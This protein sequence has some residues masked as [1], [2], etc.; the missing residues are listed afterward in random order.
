MELRHLRYFT[1]VAGELHFGRAAKL[2]RM[3]QPPLSQQIRSLEKELGVEL[4][5]R[6]KRE[7]RLTPAGKAILERA[8]KVLE[9]V[10]LSTEV[11]RRAAR[12]ETGTLEIGYVP[13]TDLA[14]LPPVIRRFRSQSP[15]VRIA[16][17]PLTTTEQAEALRESRIDFGL[18]CLPVDMG[19]TRVETLL[20]E[21]LVLAAP[22]GHP[23]LK[24]R[25][26]TLKSLAGIPF[27][28]MPRR[29]APLYH[30][31]L[32]SLARGAGVNLHI[33]WETQSLYEKL[34]VIASGLGV[35]L[36]CQSI[37]KLRR[38]GVAYRRLAPPAPR[39]GIGLCY[40]RADLSEIQKGFLRIVRSLI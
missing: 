14:I 28:A 21:P 22:K 36:F 17:R 8:R 31:H 40:R 35:S 13:P 5:G 4:L 16:L 7:V 18:V 6:T 1:A 10:D 32:L 20:R 34:C 24:E 19:N 39:I 9:E 37:Q 38:E 2:L 33:A 11:V 26:L 23:I 25:P 30:D 15:G 29:A 12:G 27:V 3:S